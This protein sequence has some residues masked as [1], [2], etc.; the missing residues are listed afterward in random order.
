MRGRA[1]SLQLPADGRAIRSA[2]TPYAARVSTQPERLVALTWNHPLPTAVVAL[3]LAPRRL[4]LITPTSGERSAKLLVQILTERGLQVDLAVGAEATNLDAASRVPSMRQVVE[5]SLEGGA[6]LD[7][8]GGSKPMAAWARL[9]LECEP[10]AAGRAV[11]LDITTGRLRWDDGRSEL[12]TSALS[13]AEIGRL[14]DTRVTHASHLDE[15]PDLLID[16]IADA[17]ALVRRWAVGRPPRLVHWR[18]VVEQVELACGR[19]PD[20]DARTVTP[21]RRDGASQ[22]LVDHVDRVRQDRDRIIPLWSRREGDWLELLVA[23]RMARAAESVGASVDVSLNVDARRRHGPRVD[24]ELARAHHSTR[25]LVTALK[26]A[27]FGPPG[28]DLRPVLDAALQR[29]GP[30]EPDRSQDTDFEV[31]VVVVRAHRIHA[32]SCYAGR[33]PE[34]LEWKAHEIARRAVQLGGEHARAAFVC[35]ASAAECETLRQRLTRTHLRDQAVAVFG[36]DDLLGWVDQDASPDIVRFLG[37]DDPEPSATTQRTEPVEHDLLATVGGSPIPVLQSVLAHGAEA[38]LLV[39]DERTARTA[40]LLAAVLRD[41]GV[42]ASLLDIGSAFVASELEQQFHRCLSSAAVDVTG[43]TKVMATQAVLHHAR[44]RGLGDVTY[45]DGRAGLL[46]HLDRPLTQPLPDVGL[47]DL[48]RLHDRRIV[49]FA[50]SDSMDLAA[51]PTPGVNED[52]VA[53]RA[54]AVALASVLRRVLPAPCEVYANVVVERVTDGRRDHLDLLVRSRSRL[55]AGVLA[56]ATDHREVAHFVWPALVVAED[57][58]GSYVRV[59]VWAPLSDWSR[60]HLERNVQG[61]SAG[62]PRIRIFGRTALERCLGG[63]DRDV[64]T[65]MG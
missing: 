51:L 19:D 3:A 48:L 5:R 32:I 10:G 33:W 50:A 47:A 26:A 14:H 7:Y 57:L 35:L 39:H 13:P 28:K 1:D 37:L 12:P 52:P 11:Y 63:D 46:R 22:W 49:D 25:A 18:K 45:V 43:G 21:S 16:G 31:D 53:R 17:T 34:R 56:W 58:A 41:H 59:A 62:A 38:P 2:V 9:R 36:I 6:V 61:R 27:P 20:D 15:R 4:I 64:I 30:D 8:T 29:R 44:S 60:S 42:R 40:A 24:G 54:A 55:G 23:E 65:W